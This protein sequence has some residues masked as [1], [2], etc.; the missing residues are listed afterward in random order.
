M[1]LTRVFA[2]AGLTVSALLLGHHTGAGLPMCGFESSC[3]RVQS[4]LG[5]VAGVLL[6]LLGV[7]GFAV[8][9][10]GSFFAWRWLRPL[11]LAAGVAGLGLILYQVVFLREVCLY[12]LGADLSAVAVALAQVRRREAQP[13]LGRRPR[14][15]WSLAAV[16]VL[17]SALLISAAVHLAQQRRVP[18]EVRA[19]WVPGKVNIV[20]V[21]DF[22]CPHCRQ[23]HKVV[24]QLLREE[25][26][27]GRIHFRCVAAPMP[28][29]EQARNAARAFLCACEQDKGEEMAGA[30]F[31][32]ADLSRQAC[33]RLAERLGLS[34]SKFRG[35]VAAPQTDQR[36]D[37][38]LAWVRAASPK[39]LPV[40]WVQDQ[41]FSGPQEL[42]TLRLAVRSARPAGETNH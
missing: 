9:F 2:L 18:A 1:Q 33:E 32:A 17:G 23:M 27:T 41:K 5:R 36:I 7:G 22:E 8:L 15:L 35:C 6:P 31:T 37:H 11:A 40:I 39:G 12:C 25:K 29:H 3:D 21:A 26:K 20:E 4:S 42:E 19:L 10:V 14:V 28:G 38:T 24:Q 30:L 13:P 34:L 16:L